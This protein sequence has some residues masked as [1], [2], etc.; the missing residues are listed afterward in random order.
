MSDGN[1]AKWQ[2]TTNTHGLVVVLVLLA[3][4]NNLL[5]S[6]DELVSSLLGEGVL[7]DLLGGVDRVGGGLSV[8]LGDLLLELVGPV[9]GLSLG[10]VS[11]DVGRVGV[12][13]VGLLVGGAGDLVPLLSER[14]VGVSRG[15]EILGVRS[16]LVLGLGLDVLLLV[17]E[18]VLGLLSLVVGLTGG[19][20]VALMV[21]DPGRLASAQCSLVEMG[22][23]KGGEGADVLG[24]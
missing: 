19:S 21:G 12:G 8:L 2:K 11:V 9:S 14:S 16:G 23:R 15:V 10:L 17:L 3:L 24:I 13:L 4:D 22:A 5:E 6:V 18:V 1:G 7:D 20:G